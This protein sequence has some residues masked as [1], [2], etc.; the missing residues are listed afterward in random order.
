[1]LGA[2]P[3]PQQLTSPPSL[4]CP[5]PPLLPPRAI[6]SSAPIKDKTN[7]LCYFETLCCDTNA[8]N[9]LINSSLTI[10]FI[11]MLKN[12]KAGPLR[13]KLA[14]VLGE[15]RSAR[16]PPRLPLVP[17]RR[18]RAWWRPSAG[19]LPARRAPSGCCRPLLPP[20]SP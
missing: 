8:A 9:I 10:L 11:R 1:M 7:V 16:P 2:A 20:P 3:G 15:R 19:T 13:V 17:G 14:S 6:A 18:L 12:A 5:L 4:S